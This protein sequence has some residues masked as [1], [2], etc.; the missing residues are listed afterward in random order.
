MT[1]HFPIFGEESLA[2]AGGD[3]KGEAHWKTIRRAI[4]PGFKKV[5]SV[6]HIT[7]AAFH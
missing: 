7:A 2:L 3:A 4:A 5:A 1:V 6:R